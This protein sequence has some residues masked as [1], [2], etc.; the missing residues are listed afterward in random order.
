MATRNDYDPAPAPGE[1]ELVLV[2]VFD[3]PRELVWKAFA[4]AGRLAQW[5][6]LAGFTMQVRTLDF[7]PGGILHYAQRSPDGRVM[8]GKFVYRDI[9][10]PNRMVFVTSFA[11]EE[12]NIIRA[13]FSPTWP[14]EILNTVTFVESEGKTTVTLHGGPIDATEEEWETFWNVQDSIR[15]GF[16]GTFDQLAAYLPEEVK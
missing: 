1:R 12:G 5:W 14:L 13:P 16:A 6:G 7:R 2:H 10:A 15:R 3:A 9:Q 4:E 8:W 11:D